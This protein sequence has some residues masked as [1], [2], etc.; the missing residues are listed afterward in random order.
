MWRPLF[1]FKPKGYK[2]TWTESCDAEPKQKLK[3][4]TMICRILFKSFLRSN[5]EKVLAFCKHPSFWMCC[6]QHVSDK[7]GQKHQCGALN[8]FTG[9]RWWCHDLVWEG[10][11]SF[12]SEDRATFNTARENCLISRSTIDLRDFTTYKPYYQKFQRTDTDC[13]E[14]DPSGSVTLKTD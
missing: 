3:Q 10:A 14:F 13:W 1:H 4:T 6:Q 7:L 12:T 5:V 11:Q 9:I 8:R 2:W